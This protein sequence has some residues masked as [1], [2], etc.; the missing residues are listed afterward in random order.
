LVPALRRPKG[1]DKQK[2]DVFCEE[3]L[4][5][6]K[7]S[8]PFNVLERRRH[9][10]KKGGQRPLPDEKRDLCRKRKKR[11]NHRIVQNFSK[12]KKK[13][14]K[15]R[16]PKKR[17]G[18]GGCSQKERHFLRREKNRKKREWVLEKSAASDPR[19]KMEKKDLVK[20]TSRKAYH[21]GKRAA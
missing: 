1:E 11:K 21:R 8:G 12:K 15:N 19:S 20:P 14:K 7:I 10:A 2:R 4:S 16:A 6:T 5:E 3:G 18:K 9:V 13:K 17:R